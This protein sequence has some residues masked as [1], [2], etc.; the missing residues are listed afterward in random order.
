MKRL[1]DAI[2]A[3]TNYTIAVSIFLSQE[4]ISCGI[5]TLLWAETP[6]HH[7]KTR[8]VTLLPNFLLCGL[9]VS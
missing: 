1:R 9:S 3:Q 2:N 5:M 8:V 4:R 7:P 6:L